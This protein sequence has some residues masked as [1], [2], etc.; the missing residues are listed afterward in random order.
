M[1]N[2]RNFLVPGDLLISSYS[3]TTE[4]DL[5]LLIDRHSDRILH[6]QRLK[7]GSSELRIKVK[8]ELSPNSTP[9]PNSSR[10][11]RIES[12]SLSGP[13]INGCAFVGTAAL[14]LGWRLL[15]AFVGRFCSEVRRPAPSK[16]LID[17]VHKWLRVREKQ[18]VLLKVNKATGGLIW[19]ISTGVG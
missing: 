9:R 12:P 7:T 14:L 4:P 15:S 6:K 19:T 11:L 3:F 10:A 17:R 2:T 18:E 8:P 16:Q 1:S 13:F 5:L